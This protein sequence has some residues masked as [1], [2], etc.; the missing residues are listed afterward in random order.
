MYAATS[1]FR[2]ILSLMI[3]ILAGMLRLLVID[4]AALL[5]L[6]MREIGDGPHPSDAA[7]TVCAGHG[8]FLQDRK[9]GALT[10]LS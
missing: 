8:C 10:A 2:I 7:A 3:F 9:G 5:A 6:G 1:A 4:C